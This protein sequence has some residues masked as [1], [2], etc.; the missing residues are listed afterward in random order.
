VIDP[1]RDD[2]DV[3]ALRLYETVPLLLPELPPVTEI[4]E[5][6]DEAFQPTFEETE[7]VEEPL[8]G[9]WL[10][11]DGLIVSATPL[12]LIVNDLVSPPPLTVI[13]PERDDVEEVDATLYWTV[14]SP[15]PAVP[16]VSEIQLSLLVADQ[17]VFDATEMLPEPPPGPTLR[18]VGLMLSETPTCVSVNVRVKPRPVTEIVA[19]RVVVAELLETLY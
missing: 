6:L 17:V 13:V 1:D 7:M 10:L 3:F 5:R 19:T 12:W 2:V 14:P 4:H 8:P 9:P 11:L 16:D 15:L 18:L